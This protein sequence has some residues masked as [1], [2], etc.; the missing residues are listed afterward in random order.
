MALAEYFLPGRRPA[1]LRRSVGRLAGRLV[2]P[3][4][5]APAED[6]LTELEA[7]ETFDS[8]SVLPQ[9]RVLVLLI[10]GDRDR[11]FSPEV[12]TQTAALIPDCTLVWYRGKG[13]SGTVVSSRVARDVLGFAVQG[14]R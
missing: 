4:F 2:A 3:M 12:V 14:V 6:L 7:E 5:A 13:H 10:A 8:R 11:C 1:W 9:V